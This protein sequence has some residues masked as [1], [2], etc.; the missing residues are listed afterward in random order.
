[1][2]RISWRDRPGRIMVTCKSIANPEEI[3]PTD[4]RGSNATHLY[5]SNVRIDKPKA[6]S[7]QTQGKRPPR[8][9]SK[10]SKKTVLRCQT[11]LER[12]WPDLITPT[13]PDGIRPNRTEP[14]SPRVTLEGL[15]E[16]HLAPVPFLKEATQMGGSYPTIK[17]GQNPN[18]TGTRTHR[19]ALE[20]PKQD[21]VAPNAV[22][23]TNRELTGSNPTSG[24]KRSRN[25]TGRNPASPSKGPNR[26]T[27]Q[28]TLS[29][30][31]SGTGRMR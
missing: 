10:I 3:T 13:E 24:T 4:S 30:N 6:D 16:T 12:N 7:R 2:M 26:P 14:R 25:G 5:N 1:M 23:G 19:V 11:L 9:P 27:L 18:R 8:S 22:L 15:E 29:A 21:H 28:R 17:T 20:G 31:R